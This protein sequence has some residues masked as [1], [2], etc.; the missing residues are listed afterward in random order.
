MYSLAAVCYTKN[1][2]TKKILLLQGGMGGEREVSLDTGRNVAQALK[3]LGHQYKVLDAGPDL[4]SQLSQLRPDYDLAF[5]ALH[6]QYAEDGMVQ[7]LCEYLKLPYTGSG[8]LGS[9]IGMDKIFA[10]DLL[11]GAN[12]ATPRWQSFST[13]PE[14]RKHS[15]PVEAGMQIQTSIE[16][17]VVVK[18]VRSGSSLG[19]SI[20]HDAKL[21]GEACLKALRYDSRVLIEEFIK[22]HDIT[23]GILDD[24]A[25]TP[26]QVVPKK[27]FYDYDNKYTDG[28]TDYLLPAPLSDEQTET[29]THLALYVSRFCQ[30]RSYGRVD[31]RFD[32]NTFYF[33]EVNTLPG[34]TRTSLVPKAAAHDGTGFD[35]LV[36]KIVH[37]ARLDYTPRPA[38]R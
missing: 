7:S 31:F 36:D 30:M 12:F 37:A 9:A 3:N 15:I 35:E 18:A 33:I 11:V 34:L 6:G 38:D 29:V 10:K 27:G 5:L 8:V 28:K 21:V 20:V 23:V 16:M 13:H 32:G 1:M 19:V 22:G 25:L 4:P 14:K 26:I 17:P 2:A 24:K